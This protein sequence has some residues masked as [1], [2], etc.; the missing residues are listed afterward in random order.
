MRPIFEKPDF[1]R[2][3]V[4]QLDLFFGLSGAVLCEGYKFDTGREFPIFSPASHH[5][6]EL[7]P[8]GINVRLRFRRSPPLDIDPGDRLRLF[9]PADWTKVQDIIVEGRG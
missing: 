4:S 1:Q 3:N 2:K 5:A 7:C 6:V 9:P 8:I